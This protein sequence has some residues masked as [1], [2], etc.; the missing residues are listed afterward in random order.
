MPWTT[1][2]GISIHYHLTGE[3][4]PVVVLLHEMGGT[5]DSWD[6][7]VP[8]LSGAYRVLRYDQRGSGLSEKVRQTYSNETAVADLEDLLSEL[9]LP[10]PY[11]LVAV[12][13]A[14]TQAM[15]FLNRHEDQVKS[16]VLCNPALGVDPSRA[17]QLEERAAQAEQNGM[18]AVLAITLEKSY[19]PEITDRA[20]YD[21][22]RGRYLANDPVGFGFANRMLAH[23]NVTSM[24]PTI[25]VPTMV[26]SGKH[27]GVRPTAVV[28]DIAR[29]INGARFE[30]IE[31][32]HFMPTTGPKPL[33]ALL[34]DFFAKA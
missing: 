5:L 2:N 22:Y 32:G 26:V 24:L 7:V 10:P 3:K 14:S 30:V 34:K 23:T 18:R 27:D 12:A 9:K 17:S 15:L 1:A 16:L 31:A 8:G 13:A 21:A 25:K 6:E 4:G 33:T 28:E 29:K 20:T 11:H 19:P